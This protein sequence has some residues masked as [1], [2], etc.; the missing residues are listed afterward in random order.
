MRPSGSASVS[1]SGSKC[2][3]ACFIDTDTDS[4]PDADKKVESSNLDF[5]DGQIKIYSCIHFF[6]WW[7]DTA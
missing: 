3:N 2:F 5:P 1:E 7:M 6:Y 4:D